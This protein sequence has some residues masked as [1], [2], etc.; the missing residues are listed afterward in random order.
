MSTIYLGFHFTVEPKEPATEILIAEL[1][2][3]DFESFVENEDGVSAYIQKELYREGSLKDLYILQSDEFTIDYTIEEIDQVNWN[4]AWEKNFEPIVVEGICHVRAPFHD[5][6]DAVYD[7]VIEPK[8]SFGTGH[9]ETTHMMIQHLLE[10]NVEGLKTLDMGCGT[11]VLAILAEMKGAHPIDAI[12]IDDWCYLNSLENIA[13][14]GCQYITVEEGDAALLAGR[15][16]DLI[17]A[18]INRNILL[19][20][21]ETYVACLRSNGLLL[22]SGFYVD[23]IPYLDKSCTEK[24]LELVKQKE[25]N[26]W[27]SLKYIKKG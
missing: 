25:R 18:N 24:G 4:E 13:R 7:L 16:Y 22:L 8:M 23:D 14:N 12:D 17:I 21:M 6:T 19:N 10:T 26:N 5:K 27:A 1:A 15:S 2:E 3:L 11:A 20:D 9:H